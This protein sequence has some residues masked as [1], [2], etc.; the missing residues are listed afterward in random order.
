M[1]KKIVV[2]DYDISNISSVINAMKFVDSKIHVSCRKN[3]IKNASHIIIPGVGA[4]KKG[5]ENLERLNLISKIIKAAE[6]GIPILGICLGMQLLMKKSEEFGTNYGLGLITSNVKK[7]QNKNDAYAFHIGW[8]NIFKT[9]DTRLIHENEKTIPFY[10]NHSYAVDFSELDC[11]TSFVKL[12]RNLTA[13]LEKDNIF[14]VQFHPEKSHQY[15]LR[16]LK[17]FVNLK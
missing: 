15:G 5:M 6:K 2:I 8:S 16:L 10:F 17:R 11:A 13:S 12:N 4:F 3:D 9:K 7:V 1:K 14:G